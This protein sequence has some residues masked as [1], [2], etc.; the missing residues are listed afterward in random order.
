L[1]LRAVSHLRRLE[2]LLG[3]WGREA[4]QVSAN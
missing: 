4:A 1:E 3:N 2:T